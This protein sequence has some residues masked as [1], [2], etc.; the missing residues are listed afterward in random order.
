MLRL[1]FPTIL[2]AAALTATAVRP[3]VPVEL[4][5]D[6][7]VEAVEKAGPA[8]VNISTERIVERRADPFSMF[9]DPF[10]DSLFDDFYKRFGY[11]RRF[12]ATSLGSG[13]VIDPEGYIVT[14]EHVIRRASKISVHFLDNSE[15][16]AILLNSDARSDIALLKVEAGQPLPCLG[17]GTSADLMIGE[18]V[19]A[20]GNPFGLENSVST[21]V[22]SGKN[23]SVIMESQEAYS[24]LLQTDA[25]VNPGNSGGP[26]LNIGAELIGINTA[27][28]QGGQSI[29]F[30]IPVD[31]VKE[32]LARL[33]DFEEV[34]GTW[35]GL[36]LEEKGTSLVVS[37][38]AGGGPAAKGGVAV[39][40]VLAGV[41]GRPVASL[42]EYRKAILPANAGDRV[43]IEVQ[44]ADKPMRFPLVVARVPIPPA[45]EL[46]Q[47]KLGVGV[48]EIT[49]SMARARR[50]PVSSG[51]MVQSVEASSPAAEAGIRPDDVLAGCAGRRTDTLDQL[52]EA[53]AKVR[54]GERIS[55]RFVRGGFIF[56]VPLTVR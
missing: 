1:R 13:V 47:K 41:N 27:I 6:A 52:R 11:T 42:L 7:V 30:A 2:L 12:R 9:T 28:Y 20:V 51:L 16:E 48:V 39:G 53:L 34:K 21:G 33:F 3:D 14:N 36:A 38:V 10:F 40:D 15:Y 56:E 49:P 19:I 22:L 23:R 43:E 54:S 31:R 50:L 17:M 45:T 5:R 55:V 37:E 32:V 24:G 18:K 44:R 35:L 4:R 29:G 8:V 26:L 46:A 25:A